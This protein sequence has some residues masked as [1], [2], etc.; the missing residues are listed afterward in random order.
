MTKETKEAIPRDEVAASLATSQE[1]GTEYNSAVADALAERIEHTV[2]ERVAAQ[3]AER[4]AET[5]G[6]PK[7]QDI[8]ITSL[9]FALAVVS[10]VV[11]VPLTLLVAGASEPGMAVGMLWLG[12]AAVNGIFVF[13]TR[14]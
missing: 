14:E 3:L 8:R 6:Q 13:A 10:M 1:L 4:L 2:D 5:Q 7:R 11:A 9:R 12:I